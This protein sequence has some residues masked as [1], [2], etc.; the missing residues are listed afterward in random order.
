MKQILFTLA[1]TSAFITAQSQCVNDPQYNIDDVGVWPDS[2]QGMPLSFVGSDYNEFIT[3]VTPSDTLVDGADFGFPILGVI[4][5]TIDDI[6]ILNVT[7]L[8]PN[9]DYA[10]DPVSC[11]FPGGEINCA[12]LY[13]T[14][15][16]TAS[17]IG[18]YNVVIATEIHAS[19]IP[20]LNTYTINDTIDYYTITIS[21]TNPSAVFD[22]LYN[23]SFELKDIYPNPLNEQSKIQVIIG[24]SSDVIFSV[25]NY[26]GETI[27]ERSIYLTRGVNDIE[28][29]DKDYANGMYLYSIN[30][31]VQILSKRLIVAN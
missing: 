10:C 14:S 18:V 31:G 12:E 7:G 30:N 24:E 29:S 21:A 6:E 17:D 4:N 16:P 3:L 5:A 23:Y 19:D 2:V 28:I 13:S 26:L 22:K 25:F 1:L 8:P 15:T 27:D 11:I 20:V 9:F